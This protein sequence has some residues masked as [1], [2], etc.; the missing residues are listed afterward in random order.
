MAETLYTFLKSATDQQSRS[1]DSKVQFGYTVD[2]Y[3]G[4]LQALERAKQQII[5]NSG[6]GVGG[7]IGGGFG[8]GSGGYNTRWKRWTQLSSGISV[9]SLTLDG[10]V[11][12]ENGSA[13]TY[14]RMV[15]QCLP[16]YSVPIDIKSKD[17]I[18]VPKIFK[19]KYP[20]DSSSPCASGITLVGGN[21]PKFPNKVINHQAFVDSLGSEK[22]PF[23]VGIFA[24]FDMD[25]LK[26]F[27]KC[28]PKITTWD[29]MKLMKL[30]QKGL[31]YAQIAFSTVTATEVK[32]AKDELE[33]PV[34]SSVDNDAVAINM[35]VIGAISSSTGGHGKIYF[36]S[37]IL[38]LQSFKQLGKIKIVYGQKDNIANGMGEEVGG[39]IIKSP[40]A[41]AKFNHQQ[42][43]IED[44]TPQLIKQYSKDT[45]E[46]ITINESNS[47]VKFRSGTTF[48]SDGDGYS[49]SQ[50]CFIRYY[51]KKGSEADVQSQFGGIPEQYAKEL[52]KG[53]KEAIINEQQVIVQG[54]GFG[55]F[56]DSVYYPDELKQIISKQNYVKALSII[57]CAEIGTNLSSPGKCE[58]NVANDGAGITYG[59]YQTT[60]K[61]GGLK[62]L[63]DKYV[64]DQKSLPNY[65]NAINEFK[66]YASESG[67]NNPSEGVKSLMS[68]LS[69]A[70]N[71]DPNMAICQSIHVYDNQIKGKGLI[72][73]FKK[74]GC[75]SALAFTIAL[76]CYN[77]GRPNGFWTGVSPD[78]SE[79][80]NCITM[81]ENEL[82]FLKKQSWWPNPANERTSNHVRWTN[83][84][85][86]AAK[87]GNFDLS[88]TQR[89]CNRVF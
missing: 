57:R 58:W 85:I 20:L 45:K 67:R 33:S 42:S 71:N 32:V 65:V 13:E 39:E 78:R 51:F 18:P 75:K 44:F 8:E 34:K 87:N 9:G 80:D 4:V 89:W 54:G 52:F 79:E 84:Y 19:S 35:Q 59:N 3:K 66:S 41:R 49:D 88:Q 81:I 60:G 17:G 40:L 72:N 47:Y 74:S 37:V 82:A 64:G 48:D 26:F 14:R 23:K 22:N 56:G 30:A 69:S 73:A 38:C 46:A 55:V 6:I 36:P 24:D 86:K 63:I 21:N 50:A 5:I 83:D 62:K 12:D 25:V 31:L 76:H 28:F 1:G 70:G 11:V 43:I 29:A 15:V 68:A 77:Q 2:S 27:T 53:A 61:S 7:G 16:Y 10:L